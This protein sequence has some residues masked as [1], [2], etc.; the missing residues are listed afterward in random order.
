MTTETHAPEVIT[1]TSEVFSTIADHVDCVRQSYEN[2]LTSPSPVTISYMI[3]DTVAL[4]N[5]IGFYFHNV[6]P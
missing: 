3:A 1:P 5:T 6:T 2:Y 4:R